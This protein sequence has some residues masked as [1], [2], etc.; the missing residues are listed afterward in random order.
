ML[1]YRKCGRRWQAGLDQI[2]ADRCPVWSGMCIHVGTLYQSHSTTSFSLEDYRYYPDQ[3]LLTNIYLQ[4]YLVSGAS[5]AL[6]FSSPPVS[7][8]SASTSLSPSSQHH[9]HHHHLRHDGGGQHS[10][11]REDLRHCG[12]PTADV[13]ISPATI[14][15]SWRTVGRI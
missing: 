2:S 15:L 11:H 13:I 14:S 3:S 7:L 1:E 10:Q 5:P 8:S 6:L 12:P 9:R 4:P